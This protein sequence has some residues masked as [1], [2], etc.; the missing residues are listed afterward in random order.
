M[1][2]PKSQSVQVAANGTATVHLSVQ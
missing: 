1:P 2:A